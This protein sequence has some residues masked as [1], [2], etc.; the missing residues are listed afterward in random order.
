MVKAAGVEAITSM[1]GLT[2][3]GRITRLPPRRSFLP[4]GEPE[5]IAILLL[6]TTL[7]GFLRRG[8]GL[9]RPAWLK[10]G[11]SKTQILDRSAVLQ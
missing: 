8:D 3:S 2:R 9:L 5:Q 1:V 6:L 4:S 10:C 7:A 11:L